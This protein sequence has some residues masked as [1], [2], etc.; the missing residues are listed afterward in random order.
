MAHALLRAFNVLEC[1]DLVEEFAG[2]FGLTP[3]RSDSAWETTISLRIP[4]AT[5]SATSVKS[6]RSCSTVPS[7]RTP[8]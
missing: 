7:T 5:T 8:R 4:P 1:S 3:A 6:V 2:E